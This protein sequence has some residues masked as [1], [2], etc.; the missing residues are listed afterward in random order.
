MIV[1]QRCHLLSPVALDWGF[2]LRFQLLSPGSSLVSVSTVKR[3]G[4]RLLYPVPLLLT[5]YP[6]GHCTS[7][8]SRHTSGRP[9]KMTYSKILKTDAAQQAIEKS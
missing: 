5:V 1:S 3:L 6:H 4:E 8:A 9:R 7:A 2:A